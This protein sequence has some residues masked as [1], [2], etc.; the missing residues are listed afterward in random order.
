MCLGVPGE[1]TSV[2][3]GDGDLAMGTVAFGGIV[4]KVCLAYVPEAKVGN[5]VIVHAGFAL[6]VL[7]EEAAREIFSYLALAV[8][9]E[10]AGGEPA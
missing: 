9:T 3:K 4:K 7:D 5:Y 8:G 2:W 10:E 1:V 6:S